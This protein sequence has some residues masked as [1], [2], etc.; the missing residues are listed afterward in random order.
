MLLTILI[1]LGMTCHQD[2]LTLTSHRSDIL[3]PDRNEP[4]RGL[5][6]NTDS[7][8]FFNLSLQCVLESLLTFRR[9]ILYSLIFFPLSFL[10]FSDSTRAH[11]VIENDGLDSW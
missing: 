10:P 5:H 11:G 1:E 7:N 4:R 6:N 8:R 9:R 2:D 3:H